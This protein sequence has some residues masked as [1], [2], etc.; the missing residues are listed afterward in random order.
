M[1]AK[2]RPRFHPDIVR[3]DDPARLQA[4]FRAQAAWYRLQFRCSDCMFVAEGG[5]CTLGWPNEMLWT[6]PPIGLDASGDPAFCKCFEA[7]EP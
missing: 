4:E 2:T 7:D 5:R 6:E 1:K 3:G